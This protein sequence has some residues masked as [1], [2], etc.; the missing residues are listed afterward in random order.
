MGLYPG[1]EENLF[2]SYGTEDDENCLK[3]KQK[4]VD[5]SKRRVVNSLV[6]TKRCWSS[7]RNEVVLSC[8]EFLS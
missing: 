1:Y 5:I 2:K 6:S 4:D 7:V 8:K 3:L